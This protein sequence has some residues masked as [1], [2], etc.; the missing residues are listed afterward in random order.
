MPGVSSAHDLAG[1]LQAA[2]LLCECVAHGDVTNRIAPH[3]FLPGEMIEWP[4]C[5][6]CSKVVL[7]LRRLED[8]AP[9]KQDVEQLAELTR[10]LR[11]RVEDLAPTPAPE[12]GPSTTRSRRGQLRVVPGAPPIRPPDVVE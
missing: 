11:R 1:P 10:D 9:I 7:E 5:G 8:L 4:I 2:E 6:Q 3:P 12:P